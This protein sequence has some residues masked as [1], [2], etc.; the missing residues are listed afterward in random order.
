[1]GCDK[2]EDYV[3]DAILPSKKKIVYV[4]DIY[5]FGIEHVFSTQEK[6]IKYVQ[7]L[8][9]DNLDKTYEW[10]IN[11]EAI[12]A[13]DLLKEIKDDLIQLRNE[14]RIEEYAYIYSAELD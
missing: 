1:M 7:D 14:S 9:I 5:E 4:V 8:Y 13:K 2:A 11:R 10:A 3:C 12:N 6:A